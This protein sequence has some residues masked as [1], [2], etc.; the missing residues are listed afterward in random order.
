M[1]K[2]SSSLK[3]KRSK[4][5]SKD[6]TSSR[7]KSRKYKS[8]KLRRQEVY[9]SSSHSDDS[10]STSLSSS[11][12]DSYRRRR[13]RSRVRKDVKGH[14]KKAQRRSYSRD[15][16]PRVRKRKRSKRKNDS[17]TRE[18]PHQ[19]KKL[20]KEASFS[21]MSGRS[22]SCSTCQGG[23]SGSDGSE[24]E[25]YRGRSERKEKDK[26]K[27]ERGRSESVRR[28]RYRARSCSSCSR[29]SESSDERTKEKYMCEN[30]SKRLRSVITVTKGAEEGR[31]LFTNESKEEIVDDHDYPSRSNDSN[32]GGAKRDPSSEEKV[33]SVE[34]EKGD[35]YA[36]FSKSNVYVARTSDVSE[37]SLDGD[38]LESILRQR[39]I[40]NLRKF[41][42]DIK[43]TSKASD[44]KNEIVTDLEQQ[45]FTEKHEQVQGKFLVNNEAVGANVGKLIEGTSSPMGRRDSTP[46]SRN[47]GRSLSGDKGKFVSVKHHSPRASEKVIDIDN[48][49]KA[50]TSDSDRTN[51]SE[52]NTTES[53]HHLLK[54]HP[55]LEQR[56][57]SDVKNNS[58]LRSAAPKQSS[59]TLPTLRNNNLNIGQDEVN[60]HSQFELKQTSAS[61]QPPNTK[62]E[63][64]EGDVDEDAVKTAQ[65]AIQIVDN[66]PRNLDKFCD[67]DT[68]KPCD[69][70]VTGENSS[71]KLLDE[72]NQGSQFEQ[73]TMNVMRG[74]EMVQVSYKV[75]I[76]KKTPALAR[77]QLKR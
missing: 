12:D 33:V 25:R 71:N 69:K 54:S 10:E 59:C 27:L 55:S 24:V 53:H 19:K 32:D 23:D 57:A 52:F 15:S 35:E 62:S 45:P 20:R 63:V 7:S 21:S 74:G 30:S 58:G 44:H 64:I 34:D 13:A 51:N 26:R 67:S 14:R 65:A 60:E 3:K 75:Y 11:S 73:K 43:L 66:S 46:S 38:D 1:G 42:G 77:R 2:S 56:P 40:E 50:V 70:S 18:K 6:R 41:R 16:S 8:K 49:S 5:S 72:V 36:D 31:E 68:L 22:W 61:R 29:S 47:N 28:G 48:P 9:L 37:D 39:A 4:K 17:K 76:P